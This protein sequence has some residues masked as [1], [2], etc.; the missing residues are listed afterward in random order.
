MI[1]VYVDGACS[2]NPGAGSWGYC[3]V[4][5]NNVLEQ[6]T[7][8]LEYT[9][10]NI[11]ELL[12]LLYSLDHVSFY[13]PNEDINIYSDSA[14]C[15]NGYNEWIYNWEKNGFINSKK[16]EVKNREIWEK[17]I[18]FTKNKKINV[19]KVKGHSGNK[20][21]TLIDRLVVETVKNGKIN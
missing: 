20:F 4:K 18:P 2:M 11:C 9:T 10:N 5:G 12:A 17:I 3:I 8:Y 19:L 15:V 21:N 1:E 14:Y 13:Y 6:K 7:E 16:E